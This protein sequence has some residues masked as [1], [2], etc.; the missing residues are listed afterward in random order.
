MYPNEGFGTVRC[1]LLIE[2]SSF[3]GVLNKGIHCSTLDYSSAFWRATC[4]CIY[5][6]QGKENGGTQGRQL[7]VHVIS[8][9]KS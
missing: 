4:T 6:N 8:E 1:V 5:V 2:V 9:K 3:Q 7:H